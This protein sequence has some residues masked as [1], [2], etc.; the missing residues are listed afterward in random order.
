MP[1]F[2]FPLLGKI[3]AKLMLEKLLNMKNSRT[4]THCTNNAVTVSFR[5]G[6]MGKI[7]LKNRSFSYLFNIVSCFLIFEYKFY[8]Q[9]SDETV[10]KFYQ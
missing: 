7:K 4:E 3:V 8:L 9:Q 1:K 5:A 10:P 6:E 2:I